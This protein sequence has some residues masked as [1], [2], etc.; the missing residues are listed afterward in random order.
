MKLLCCLIPPTPSLISS[1]LISSTTPSHIPTYTI[2]PTPILIS[3][4]HFHIFNESN[5]L[6]KYNN[7]QSLK[8]SLIIINC[9]NMSSI[10]MNSKLHAFNCT[11]EKYK[12]YLLALIYITS[13]QVTIMLVNC[14]F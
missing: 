11:I 8:S 1:T 13:K 7:V 9:A 3:Q 12:H 2:T 10:E 6:F 5:E 4:S 14:I